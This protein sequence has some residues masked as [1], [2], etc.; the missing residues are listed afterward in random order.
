MPGAEHIGDGTVFRYWSWVAESQTVVRPMGGLMG[1]PGSD[2]RLFET[3]NFV[4]G[5]RRFIGEFGHP[6]EPAFRHGSQTCGSGLNE[7]IVAQ[8]R[9]DTRRV[10]GAAAGPGG[11]VWLSDVSLRSN[12][13]ANL[14]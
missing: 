12:G 6:S 10:Q 5:R 13:S 8:R 9:I 3:S 2:F 4:E 11:D 14:H 1:P 7:W